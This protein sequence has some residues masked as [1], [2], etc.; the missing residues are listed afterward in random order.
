MFY[1]IIN[2]KTTFYLKRWALGGGLAY[3]YIYYEYIHRTDE[4]YEYILYPL[5]KKSGWC[6]TVS[7]FKPGVHVHSLT[8]L[9]WNQPTNLAHCG[10]ACTSP[11]KI[12]PSPPNQKSTPF[13]CQPQ[14]KSSQ[15]IIQNTSHAGVFADLPSLPLLFAM[16][17][18]VSTPAEEVESM[19]WQLTVRSWRRRQSL[20]R[21][22]L[23]T[24]YPGHNVLP[25]QLATN[26]EN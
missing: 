24:P 9:H 1:L 25:P 16:A 17:S 3:I 21:P 7:P 18:D 11:K 4:Q 12:K 22:S 5:K 26:K 10:I 20:W 13:R 8:Q 2:K 19:P 15:I 23:A 14:K 6:F